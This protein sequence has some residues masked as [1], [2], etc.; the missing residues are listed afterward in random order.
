MTADIKVATGVR[1]TDKVSDKWWRSLSVGTNYSREM[2]F[3]LM[4]L[5]KA[6]KKKNLTCRNVMLEKLQRE[7]Q[8]KI[9]YAAI[10]GLEKREALT[11]LVKGTW[12]PNK[13]KRS[14]RRVSVCQK[15]QKE[16]T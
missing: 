13:G 7:T 2:Q 1:I 4:R 8:H 14:G 10:R 5:Q 6:K 11:S 3:D 12:R 15:W 16:S 9:E